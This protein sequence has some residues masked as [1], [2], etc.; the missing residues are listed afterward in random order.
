MLP[1]L[2][3]EFVR[4]VFEAFKYAEYL[5][6]VA[7]ARARRGLPDAPIDSSDLERSPSQRAG[8]AFIAVFRA[9]ANAPLDGK[10]VEFV[11][12]VVID[13]PSFEQQLLDLV[14]PFHQHR[15]TLARLVDHLDGLTDPCAGADY[16]GPGDRLDP[17][18]IAGLGNDDS[19]DRFA[20]Q[21]RPLCRLASGA[22]APTDTVD[23]A[24]LLGHVRRVVVGGDGVVIDAGRKQRCFTRGTKHAAHVQALLD[25]YSGRCTYPGC[26][27]RHLETDHATEWPKGG[28]TSPSNADLLCRFHNLIKTGRGFTARRSPRGWTYH[29]PDGSPITTP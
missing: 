26:R 2:E 29:R 1:T 11:V 14:D 23:I 19:I 21:T 16:A 15:G 17:T 25:G 7:A 28:T 10:P 18:P 9:A 3:G 20:R 12:D 6:D 13:Q 8:D 27:N 5:A 22:T 4:E 24:L